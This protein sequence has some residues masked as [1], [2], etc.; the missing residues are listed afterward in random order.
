MARGNLAEEVLKEIPE[1]VCL[2]MDG[3]GFKPMPIAFDP[4]M[5]NVMP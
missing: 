5:Y 1:Q 4:A 3:I 2:Y